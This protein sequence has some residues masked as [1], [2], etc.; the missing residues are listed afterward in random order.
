VTS[1]ISRREFLTLFKR[2]EMILMAPSSSS[3]STMAPSAK[4]AHSWYAL[5][6][7]NSLLVLLIY[8]T[9]RL[10]DS[11]FFFQLTDWLAHVPAGGKG[12]LSFEAYFY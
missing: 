5:S 7:E 9:N 8:G 4:T 6:E 3:C 11:V 2:L 1:G 12:L 10:L